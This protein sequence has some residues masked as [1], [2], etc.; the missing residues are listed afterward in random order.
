MRG[1]NGRRFNQR[2]KPNKMTPKEKAVELVEYFQAILESPLTK[3]M[4]WKE[5]KQC[6]IIAAQNEIDLVTRIINESIDVQQTL[7]T[8]KKLCADILNPILKELEEVKE[9]IKKL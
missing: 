3:G 4:F 7:T 2:T 9:E 1:E 6:A 5:A 8:P